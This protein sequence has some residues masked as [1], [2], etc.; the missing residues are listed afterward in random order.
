M[1]LYFKICRAREE[2]SRLDVEVC[3]LVTYIRDEDTCLRVSEDQLK[4]TSPALA[5]QIA[6]LRNIRGRFNSH[7]L[8]RLDDI[9]K[10][11]G[12]S[13][14]IVPGKE[15]E[16]EEEEIAEEA[17]RRLQDVLLITEDRS[18]LELLDNLEE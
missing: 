17:S 18:R 3:H 7:H 2:I 1:D 16:E 4:V 6:I 5:H 13:G 14:T 15:E 10:L 11:S 9:S 8:K 12:F